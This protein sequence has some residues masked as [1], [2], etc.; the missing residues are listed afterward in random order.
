MIACQCSL[1][2]FFLQSLYHYLTDHP[3]VVPASMKQIHYFKYYP[4]R[5]IKWYLSHFPTATNFLSSGALITGE[6]SPGYLPYPD[7][8]AMV[9]QR[10]PNGPRIIV[11]GREPVDRAY[12]SYRYNYVSPTIEIMK[13]GVI[14]GI[15]KGQAD[16]YYDEY[17]FSF[18]DMIQAE[19][20]ILRECLSI[21]NGSAVSGA[22]TSWGKKSWALEEYERRDQLGL[23]PLVDLDGHCYGGQV[24]FTILRKQWI[25]LHAKYPKKL[26]P[27]KNVHLTQAMIGRGLYTFPLEW[28]YSVFNSSDIYFVCTEELKDMSGEP[29]NKL[30]QFLGLQS[31]NFSQIVSRGAYNVGSHHGYDNEVSWNEL[32]VESQNN[33]SEGTGSSGI[34]DVIPLSDQVRRDLE[35]FVR[36]YN[37]RLFNLVGRRCNW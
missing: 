34:V 25:N 23:D 27:S 3:R 35:D 7:V 18:E 33:I 26:I 24:N 2:P 19:L 16:E 22:R 5:P 14:H 1:F 6:A 30:G 36:P 11:I 17:L 8:A 9:R 13:K 12:S 20:G 10:L 4:D 32:E 28:W 37:E 15:P 31:F 29:L 21:P